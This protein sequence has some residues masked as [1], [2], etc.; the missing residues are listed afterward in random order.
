VWKWKECKCVHFSGMKQT[1]CKNS[2]NLG[3]E[4]AETLFWEMRDLALYGM[5]GENMH[6]YVPRNSTIISFHALLHIGQM[7]RIHASS[8]TSEPLLHSYHVWM[9]VCMHAH[10]TG[11]HACRPLTCT[12]TPSLLAIRNML[13]YTVPKESLE[14]H[15]T[16]QKNKARYNW[17]FQFDSFSFQF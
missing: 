7:S 17:D 13:Q 4:V 6:R 9:Y 16:L 15:E 8:S 5:A 1:S 12:R 3:C 2:A 14:H 11:C 10:I